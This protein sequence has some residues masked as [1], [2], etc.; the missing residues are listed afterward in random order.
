MENVRD[1]RELSLLQL[2]E[3]DWEEIIFFDLLF[4]EEKD[5]FADLHLTPDEFLK[6]CK[7]YL[8]QKNLWE[9]LKKRAKERASLEFDHPSLP[10]PFNTTYK[11]WYAHLLNHLT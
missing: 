8:D 7:P 2:F 1:L 5:R 4:E 3:D 6:L 10:M 11:E 9:E